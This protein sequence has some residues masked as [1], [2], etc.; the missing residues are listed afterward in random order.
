LRGA[1]V[2]SGTYVQ[3]RATLQSGA[4]FFVSSGT[5]NALTASTGT[6]TTVLSSSVTVTGPGT[7]TGQL[8]GKGTVNNDSAPAGYLG[9]SVRSS[10][11]TAVSSTGNLQFFDITSVTLSTG[12]WDVS[13]LVV[14]TL[15][16]ATQTVGLMAIT[17]TSGNSTTGQI[18]GDNRCAVTVPVAAN[19][20]TGTIANYRVSLAATTIYYLK[21]RCDFSAGTPKAFGRISARRVR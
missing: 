4:T 6:I 20:S 8:I 9:E 5:V 7:F 1:S 2:S 12:D 17:S 3:N 11:T 19:D 15:N 14:F 16:G 13:G 10:V 18:D 21:A